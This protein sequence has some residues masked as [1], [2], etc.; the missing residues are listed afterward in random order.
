[1]A[2]SVVSLY[3][4]GGLS[5]ENLSDAEQAHYGPIGDGEAFWFPGGARAAFG[6]DHYDHSP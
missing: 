5:S 2:R 1:M 4:V 3:F 6:H